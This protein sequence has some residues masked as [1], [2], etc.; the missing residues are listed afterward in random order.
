MQESPYRQMSMGPRQLRD[1]SLRWSQVYPEKTH[2]SKTYG[3]DSPDESNSDGDDYD[4]EAPA[5]KPVHGVRNNHNQNVYFVVNGSGNSEAGGGGG[6]GASPQVYASHGDEEPVRE[7]GNDALEQLSEQV[8]CLTRCKIEDRNHIQALQAAV[9]EMSRMIADMKRAQFAGGQGVWDMNALCQR[10]HAIEQQQA[11]A[12][13]QG[14]NALCQRMH[15]IEQEQANLKQNQQNL[16]ANQ[17]D[18]FQKI[19]EWMQGRRC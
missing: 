9:T 16:Y 19:S 8:E 3:A 11:A 5:L 6:G 14:M 1:E 2:E 18:V 4:P 7:G 13:G 15:A 17:Q 10:I 12:G